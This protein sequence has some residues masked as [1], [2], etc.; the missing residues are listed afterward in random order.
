M[1][2]VGEIEDWVGHSPEQV[3]KMRDALAALAA[4]GEAV[5]QD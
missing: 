1:R 5:I 2:V 3:Q 4:R